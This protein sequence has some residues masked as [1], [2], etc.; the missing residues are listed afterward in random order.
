MNSPSPFAPVVKK[1]IR[2]FSEL[3]DPIS[4]GRIEYRYRCP[5]CVELTGKPDTSG[6]LY[7]NV[8]KRVG[9]CWKCR[10]VI[11]DD[12][13]LDIG[14]LHELY[15]A[16]K[17][18][19]A[20]VEYDL[21]SWSRPVDEVPWA[22]RYLNKRRITPEIARAYGIRAGESPDRCI[23]LPDK[24]LEHGRTNFFQVRYIDADK[25]KYTNPTDAEKPLYGQFTLAGKDK[26]FVCEGCF[27]SI[28]MAA[29][30]GW[31]SLATYGK[32]VS[33]FQQ[34]ELLKL[35]G[36]REF[37]VVYDGGEFNSILTTAELLMG[38]VPNV[39][40]LLLPF[41]EDPN[42]LPMESIT[43]A[44]QYYRLPINAVT[45]PTVSAYARKHRVRNMHK[46]SW[47]KL[48]QYVQSVFNPD[49]DSDSP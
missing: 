18:K 45:L 46:E 8:R 40:V 38:V 1:E 16:R 36:I 20:A 48:R 49:P 41:K 34:G 5:F 26:A 32:S 7:F 15:Y 17:E 39:S 12:Y 4:K 14:S 42:S 23:V 30:P 29:V 9:S 13:N 43:A 33:Q 19:E 31:G 28:S 3:R 37:C 2:R 6:S 10:V 35:K 24:I 11:I 25:I 21:R 22:V 47:D 27:S 44:V